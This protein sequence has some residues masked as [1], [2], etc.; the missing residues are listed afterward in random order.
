MRLPQVDHAGSAHIPLRQRVR[1]RLLAIVQ[2]TLCGLTSP[3]QSARSRCSSPAKS[4]PAAP[5]SAAAS[6]AACATSS[7]RSLT[8]HPLGEGTLRVLDWMWQ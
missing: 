6:I 8:H 3:P 4:G 2:N 1:D 5:R 7:S